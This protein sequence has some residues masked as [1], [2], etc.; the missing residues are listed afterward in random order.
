M[1]C[2][3]CGDPSWMG[4]SKRKAMISREELFVSSLLYFATLGF[5]LQRHIKMHVPPAAGLPVDSE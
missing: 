1:T 3:V 5:F 2:H 4:S